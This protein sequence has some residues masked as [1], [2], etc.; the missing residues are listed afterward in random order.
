MVVVNACTFL[1]CLCSQLH[2]NWLATCALQASGAGNGSICLWAVK[3][4]KGGRPESLDAIGSV[5]AAGFI[6]GLQ[7][8]TSGR[9]LVAG[10]GQEPRLGRWA[11]IASARNGVLIH[12]IELQD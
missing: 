2:N 4:G 6:N 11:R 1:R 12:P 8:A 10:I 7:L 5:P 3:N 9:F